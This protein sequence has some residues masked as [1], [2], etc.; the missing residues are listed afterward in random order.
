MSETSTNGA[1]AADEAAGGR[2]AQRDVGELGRGE[3]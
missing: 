1:G 2:G 3:S